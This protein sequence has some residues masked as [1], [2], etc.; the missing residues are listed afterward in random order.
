LIFFS[1][2]Q[3]P[4]AVQGAKTRSNCGHGVAWCFACNA[5]NTFRRGQDGD[6]REA[7]LGKN[8][9]AYFQNA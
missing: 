8:P 9:D 1:T 7:R 4:D 5:K 6:Q 2:G 3:L